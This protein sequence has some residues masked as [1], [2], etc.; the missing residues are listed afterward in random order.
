[1]FACDF[2][3]LNILIIYLLNP[4]ERRVRK[5]VAAYFKVKW[6]YLT[7]RLETSLSGLPVPGP[8]FK[9]EAGLP[10]VCPQCSARQ[11]LSFV[12]KQVVR[13]RGE[14]PHGFVVRASDY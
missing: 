11:I 13:I 8:I 1:M 9:T 5:K 7:A 6:W 3:F 4:W 14:Q 12:K 2:S 10:A